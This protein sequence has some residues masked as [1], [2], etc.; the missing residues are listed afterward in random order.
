M[1]WL[2]LTLPQGPVDTA[3]DPYRFS[4][5][6]CYQ[7]SSS[8]QPPNFQSESPPTWS[9]SKSPPF[10]LIVLRQHTAL[11]RLFGTGS[12]PASCAA[13]SSTLVRTGA[14]CLQFPPLTLNT[15]SIHG[16][17]SLSLSHYRFISHLTDTRVLFLLG[18]PARRTLFHPFHLYFLASAAWLLGPYHD[19]TKSR[20]NS[21]HTLHHTLA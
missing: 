17:L 8:N 6:A 11:W 1:A 13:C 18:R 19:D 4:T 9:P 2:F 16:S 10:L 21:T 20:N 7:P 3:H 15:F 14:W 12:A 5:S